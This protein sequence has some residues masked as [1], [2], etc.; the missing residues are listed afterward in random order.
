MSQRSNLLLICDGTLGKSLLCFSPVSYFKYMLDCSVTLSVKLEKKKEISKV[1]NTS[2][3]FIHF[4]TPG[5][6]FQVE[7]SMAHCLCLL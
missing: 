7:G 1:Q 2:N 6:P 3:I 4:L 5:L